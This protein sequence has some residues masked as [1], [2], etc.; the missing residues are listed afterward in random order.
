MSSMYQPHILMFLF[1][2]HSH[3]LVWPHSHV[4]GLVSFPCSCWPHSMFL[5]GLIPMFLFWSHSHVGTQLLIVGYVGFRRYNGRCTLLQ[6]EDPRSRKVCMN[7]KRPS[8]QV[9]P[10]PSP[11]EGFNHS[12]YPLVDQFVTSQVTR[13][14]VQGSIRRWTFFPQGT[15]HFKRHISSLHVGSSFYPEGKVVVYDIMDNRWCE[16]IGRTHKSNNIM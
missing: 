2:S 5:S 14:G 11:L 16:N 4:L 8:R 1:W 7:Q 3:V 13:G 10:G 12:P 15:A 9:S 6:F